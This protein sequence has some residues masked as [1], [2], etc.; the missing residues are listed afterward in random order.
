MSCRTA[1]VRAHSRPR[2]RGRVVDCHRGCVDLTEWIR[3]LLTDRLGRG[4]CRELS[5]L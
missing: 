4:I 5:F 3:Y 1:P 2:E